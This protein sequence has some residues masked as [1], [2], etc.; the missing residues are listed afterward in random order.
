MKFKLKDKRDRNERLKK[1]AQEHPDYT[2]DAIARIFHISRSRVCRILQ[3][4]V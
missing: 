2:Q 4:K 3:I 1:F